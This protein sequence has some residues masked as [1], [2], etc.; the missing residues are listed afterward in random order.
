MYLWVVILL[1]GLLPMASVVAEV[2]LHPHVSLFF[3][4]GR[5]FVFW[6]VGV[7]L[8][9]AGLRQAI[10]PNFTARKIF[11]L[12]GDAPLIV[13]QELGFANIAIGLIGTVS[14]LETSWIMPAAVSGGLFYGLAGVKHA[15]TKGKRRLQSVAMVS[16]LFV[17]A[18]LAFFVAGS[19]AHRA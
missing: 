16:D 13:V 19:L 6:A 5:W 3:Q 10:Q 17:F 9:M 11:E 4:T 2:L 14:V 7:R 1:T 18:V 15:L 12:V 8:L